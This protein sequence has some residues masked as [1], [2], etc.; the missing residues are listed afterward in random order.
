MDIHKNGPGL[1]YYQ[2]PSQRST[3]SHTPKPSFPSMYELE[4][5]KHFLLFTQVG[6]RTY[7]IVFVAWA[8]WP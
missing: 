1:A 4:V 7:K 2:K 5:Q 6:V 8:V 3:I